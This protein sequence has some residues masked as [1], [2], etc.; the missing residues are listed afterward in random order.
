MCD[1]YDAGAV[2][3]P[4]SPDIAVVDA[5]GTGGADESP[6]PQRLRGPSNKPSRNPRFANVIKALI[7][8]RARRERLLE[9]LLEAQQGLIAK[10]GAYECWAR[11]LECLAAATAPLR[12]A[13]LAAARGAAHARGGLGGGGRGLLPHLE[14]QEEVARDCLTA[15]RAAAAAGAVVGKR[16]AAAAPLPPCA[17]A[18]APDPPPAGAGAGA[19]DPPP[20]C[21]GAGAPPLRVPGEPEAGGAAG[22]R[23]AALLRAAPRECALAY[24]NFVL[25][26]SPE[27]VSVRARRGY[28][29]AEAARLQEAA[30]GIVAHIA[31]LA[32]VNPLAHM[33]GGALRLD[34]L[35][36]VEAR[37]LS[38]SALL[39]GFRAASAPTAARRD[40]L[41]AA[42]A[43][44]AAAGRDAGPLLAAVERCNVQYLWQETSAALALFGELL[45]PEQARSAAPRTASAHVSAWPYV[46]LLPALV[47]GLDAL[48]APPQWQP[49]PQEPEPPEPP[50]LDSDGGDAAAAEQGRRLRRRRSQQRQ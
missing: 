47:S 9:Q 38:V 48:A 14:A 4:P 5:D 20:N 7:K 34:A 41:A 11:A 13:A 2:G 23:A 44:A 50:A 33:G 1:G 39:T 12:A 17:G 31:A 30:E 46:P 43:A 40:A 6:P 10:Q 3:Q 26:T 22:A 35:A 19:P 45:T 15:L 29:P 28:A 25:D 16:G 42:A 36:P 49:N 21:A 24:A 37:E 32:V 27:L 18:G 8:Q